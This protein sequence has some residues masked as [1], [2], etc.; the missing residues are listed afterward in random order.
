LTTATI[1]EP[2]RLGGGE[3]GVEPSTATQWGCIGEALV[4]TAV[5]AAV[6]VST[7]AARHV[8]GYL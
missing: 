8:D 5:R 7:V 3:A 4:M 1:F 2:K 6:R